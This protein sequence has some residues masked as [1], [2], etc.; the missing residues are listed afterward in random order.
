MLAIVVIVVFVVLWGWVGIGTW[1]SRDAPKPNSDE[2]ARD[3]CATCRM[4]QEWYNSLSGPEQALYFAWWVTRGAVC[5]A[6]G[7]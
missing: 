4:E 2:L 5:A 6:K 3:K 1:A 7:C